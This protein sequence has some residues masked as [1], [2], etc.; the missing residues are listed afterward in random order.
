MPRRN[1]RLARVVAFTVALLAFVGCGEQDPPAPGPGSDSDSRTE[2]AASSRPRVFGRAPSFTLIDQDGRAFASD[3]LAGRVWIANFFFTR[4]VATCPVQTGRLSQLQARWADRRPRDELHFLSLSIDPRND[5][6]TAL[7]K[8]AETYGADLAH[9]SFLTGDDGETS[10]LSSHAFKLPVEPDPTNTRMP[11]AH[12]AR[13]VLVDRRGLVRG[14]FDSQTDAGVEELV[15]ATETVL[16]EPAPKAVGVPPDVFDTS[17]LEARA[18]KQIA[19]ARSWKVVHDFR[20]RDRRLSSGIRFVNRVVDDCGKRYKAVHYDHGNGVAVADVDGDGLLD[21]YFSNQ[22][23]SNQLWRNRGD[24]TFE[25]IT[26]EAGVAVTDPVGVTASFGDLDNDGDPDLF[27]TTVRGGNFLFVNDGEGAFKDVTEAAG[28]VYEGHSS[29]AV[30]FDFDRDGRLDIFVCNVGVYTT[31]TLR[32][33]IDDSTTAGLPPGPF[34]YYEGVLDGFSGHLKPARSEVSL[35]YRNLG[36]NRFELVNDRVGLND[37]TWTGAASPIDVNDD[38]WVDLYVLSMQGHDEYYENVAGKRFVKRSRAVFPKTSWGA[39]CMKVFDFDTDGD[40]DFFITDMHSDMSQGVDPEQAQ[41]KLKSD[42]VWPESILRSEGKSVWGNTFFENK[43]GGRYKE[44]SD[45]IGAET[46]WPWGISVGDLNADGYEDVFVAASMNYMFRYGVNSVLLN[47]GG[48]RFLDSEFVLGV[49]PRRGRLLK[50]WFDL[51][52][53]TDGDHFLCKDKEGELVAWA[54]LGSRSSVIFDLDDDGDLDV[55]TNDCNSEPLVLVSDLS[56][57]REIHFLKVALRGTKSNRDGLGAVVR[58]TF[59]GRTLTQVYD[60][61][62][63]YLSQ[64]SKPLYF[65][66]GDAESVDRIEVVWPS[67]S[68]QVVTDDIAVDDLIVLREP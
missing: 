5:T 19:A 22:V 14:Y 17:W 40:L 57:R 6:P 8:Y 42:M 15:A 61:Q 30:L 35:L 55:V 46:Y 29:S 62:S 11:I 63:G 41:E 59:A 45:A 51:D 23:G 44:V 52:C 50:P 38:G 27:V 66:L 39:M 34:Y 25:D 31:N 58:V 36:E 28:L 20:F 18:A 9:W 26:E 13:F 37:K 48:K 56:D 1:R 47:D 67:G 49:E 2:P 33:V 43:G 21:I 7:K 4:C 16:A 60:G 3:V 68:K 10:A 53:S 64:S 65:G 54:P 32:R 12:S 24:G